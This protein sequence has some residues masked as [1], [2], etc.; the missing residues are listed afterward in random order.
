MIVNNIVVKSTKVFK[1]FKIISH[2]IGVDILRGDLVVIKIVNNK[3]IILIYEE[4][5]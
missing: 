4:L 3:S 2:M 5:D 1:L